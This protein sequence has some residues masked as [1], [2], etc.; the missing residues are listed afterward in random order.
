MKDHFLEIH[1]LT[2]WLHLGLVDQMNQRTEYQWMIL[3]ESS[4]YQFV[5]CGQVALQVSPNNLDSSWN[6]LFCLT[7]TQNQILSW[8]HWNVQY[9][10][11]LHFLSQFLARPFGL[12]LFQKPFWKVPGFT[13]HNYGLGAKTQRTFLRLSGTASRIVETSQAMGFTEGSQGCW[14][15]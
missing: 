7:L 5:S 3:V 13:L 11:F 14:E 10:T 2:A 9:I 12:H 8:F 15:V 1:H 4:K 6:I